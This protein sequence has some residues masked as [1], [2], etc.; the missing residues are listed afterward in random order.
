MVF[1]WRDDHTQLVLDMVQIWCRY[2]A[3]MVQIW[4]R[5][6]FSHVC[7]LFLYEWIYF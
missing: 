2:G 6:A 1:K 5:Y 3:D 7:V 4:C